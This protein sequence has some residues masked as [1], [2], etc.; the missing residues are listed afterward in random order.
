METSA[1][2]PSR[3]E[4]A[5]RGLA[6]LSDEDLEHLA[7]VM[8]RVWRQDN[9]IGLLAVVLPLGGCTVLA[10][11]GGGGLIGTAFAL[12]GLGLLAGLVGAGILGVLLKRSLELEVE[13]LGYDK[14]TSR[15]SVKAVRKAMRSFLPR[16]TRKQKLAACRKALGHARACSLPSR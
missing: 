4:L 16:I 13:S 9:L 3:T 14:L 10:S 1:A 12:G 5:E 7:Q 15:A 11:I 2:V 6:E 8:E